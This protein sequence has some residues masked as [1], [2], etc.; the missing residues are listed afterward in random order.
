MGMRGER[1]WDMK[2]ERN[3]ARGKGVGAIESF[4]EVYRPILPP[5]LAYAGAGAL[6]EVCG[7]TWGALFPGIPWQPPPHHSNHPFPNSAPHTT[8]YRPPPPGG[9][10]SG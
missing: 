7:G 1:S 4:T 10:Y 9:G 6:A 5:C 2:R 3:V 8:R